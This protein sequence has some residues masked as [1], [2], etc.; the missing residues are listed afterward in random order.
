[1]GAGADVDVDD[2]TA[3]VSDPRP[4]SPPPAPIEQPT[5]ARATNGTRHLAT[6]ATLAWPAATARAQTVMRNALLNH[7]RV[8]VASIRA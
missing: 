2:G 1:M 8:S 5:S 7:P 3:A 6:A 4:V